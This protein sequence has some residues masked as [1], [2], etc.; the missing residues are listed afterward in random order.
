MRAFLVAL[1]VVAALAV[2]AVAADVTDPL[3]LNAAQ[4]EAGG[5]E[6]APLKATERAPTV[7]AF[8][9]VLNLGLLAAASAKVAA[10]RAAVDQAKAKRA[11]AQ[12]GEARAATLFHA[13]H[14]ISKAQYQTAQA[15]AQVA[16]ANVKVA[17]VQLR[18]A[19]AQIRADW[20]QDLATAISA[21]Q[22]PVPQL[23][24]GSACLVQVTLPF[25]RML[26]SI[27]KKAE[28]KSPAGT[29]LDMHLVGPS[30]RSPTGSGPSYFYLG[31]GS[32]CPPVG[33]MLDVRL[34]DGPKRKGVVVPASAVVWRSGTKLI[35]RAEG[36]GKFVPVPLDNTVAVSG[37]YFIRTAAHGTLAPGQK[38]V[39]RGAGLLLS[40]SEMPAPSSSAGGGDDDD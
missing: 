22:A 30:P 14:N 34:P 36:D 1:P 20:G 8:G 5:I 23:V 7:A 4:I 25:G 10:V 29:A 15:N 19:E 12:A 37:G 39:V 33:I 11:L 35:Y 28:G 31:S 2:P 16:T 13:A 40:Q 3:V 17:Q 26:P 27:P 9:E 32:G 21:D 6:T 38:I 18:S 24:N